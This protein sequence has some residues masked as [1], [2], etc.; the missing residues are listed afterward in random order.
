MFLKTS[1]F[2]L[3]EVN[4]EKMSIKSD[5]KAL[6]FLMI[7]LLVLGVI[8][9]VTFVVLD[10][11]KASLCT[12]N[13]ATNV[14]DGQTCALANGSGVTLSSITNVEVV[15]AAIVIALSFLAVVVIVIMARIILRVTRELGGND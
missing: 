7:G 10:Q 3:W 4:F 9:G 14:W 15:E 2:G 5:M 12:Q 13:V 11:F 8:V 1:Q 6:G